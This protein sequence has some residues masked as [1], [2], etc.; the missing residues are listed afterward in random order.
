MIYM[1]SDLHGVI[2]FEGLNE[3]IR[4]ATADDLLIILG[5]V[6][7]KFENNEKNRI[8][9]EQF[10]KID[11]PIAIVDGNHENHP[12]FRSHP[13]E[14]MYGSLVY[15]LT[16]NIVCLKRGNVYEI[17]GKSFF[18]MGGCKSSQRWYDIGLWFEH[19]DPS[20]E[21][22]KLAYENLKSRSNK[23]DYV[24]THKYKRWQPEL[25]R[26]HSLE[27]LTEYIE[28][29]VE[30]RHWF[31]GHWHNNERRDDRHTIVYDKLYRLE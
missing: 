5:D 4:I 9:T 21:E 10:L 26:P 12:Y 20:E 29:S 15:R 1:I 8:F 11:K 22:I 6:G 7:L 14:V 19:E 28:D 16:D 13:E 31:S 18:V 17:E 24:L 23:V 3:Y 27:E 30:Y 25:I 2:D